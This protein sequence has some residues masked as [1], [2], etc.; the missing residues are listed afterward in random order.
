M[1]L[2]K[3]RAFSGIFTSLVVSGVVFVGELKRKLMAFVPDCYLLISHWL[4][5][6]H[7]E[8]VLP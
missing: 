8:E 2:K 4:M 5:C 3:G 7:I 1:N 6:E